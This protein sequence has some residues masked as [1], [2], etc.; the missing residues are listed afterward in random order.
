[1]SQALTS[2]PLKELQLLP[3]ESLAGTAKGWVGTTFL[4]SN[5]SWHAGWSDATTTGR[6]EPNRSLPLRWLLP[7]VGF[8]EKIIT[9][10]ART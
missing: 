10:I 1:M 8:K 3:E 4:R 2:M 9:R 7:P 5:G 6:A